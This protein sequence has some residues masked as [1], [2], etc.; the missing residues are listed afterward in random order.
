[1]AILTPPT[2]RADDCNAFVRIWQE[3]GLGARGLLKPDQVSGTFDAATLAATKKYQKAR[4]LKDDG[5]VGPLTWGYAGFVGDRATLAFHKTVM[6][7]RAL[8]FLVIHHS[9]S[10]VHANLRSYVRAAVRDPGSEAAEAID[11]DAQA[12][13]FDI[14]VNRGLSTN[15]IIGP[16]GR[17]ATCLDPRYR[18]AHALGWNDRSEGIDIAAPLDED[19]GSTADGEIWGELATALWAPKS[20]ERRYRRDTTHAALALHKLLEERCK[21]TGIPYEAPA[22]FAT[23]QLDPETA[24][25]GVYAHGHLSDNRWD[26]YSILQRMKELGVGPRLV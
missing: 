24:P 6:R 10:G 9:V 15:R 13:V 12:K 25:P 11:R 4:G 16:F 23:L 26:G 5:I 20:D 17:V 18:A 7:P 2:L 21:E 22:K 19:I 14:L 1:M 8:R 3:H